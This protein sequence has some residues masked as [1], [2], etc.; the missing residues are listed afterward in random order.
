MESKLQELTNKLYNEGVEKANK[1]AEQILEDAKK[2]AGKKEKEARE[3]AEEIIENAKKEAEDLKKNVKSELS[4]AA[5]Q[6]LREVKKQI[7]ELISE[8]AVKEP[9]KESLNDTEFIKKI[10]EETIKNWRPKEGEKTDV[11]VMIPKNMEKELKQHLENT[12]AKELKAGI[13]VQVS[14]QMKGGFSIAP[15]D[16]TY[17]VTFSDKD[18]ENFFK[19]YLRPKTVEMLFEKEQKDDEK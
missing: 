7:T 19:A 16:G 18:F 12:I 1:E 10:I 11:T 2:E 6:T 9:V 5:T 8:K 14:E 15:S 17:K 4:L 3:K 13:T